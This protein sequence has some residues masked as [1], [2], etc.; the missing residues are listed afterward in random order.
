MPLII[1]ATD[2]SAVAENAANYACRLAMAQN[3]QLTIIHSF[4]F[5]V[6][7][8]DIPLPAN[9]INDTED[10]LD[11]QMKKL[12]TRLKTAYPTLNIQGIVIDGDLIKS[13]EE[14]VK[15]N[16][17]PWLVV[18]GN[19][20]A[21]EYNTWESIVLA[22]FK[23][24]KYPVLAVPPGANYKQVKKICLAFDNK[25]EGND[26]A[27]TQLRDI[28]LALNAEL[29]ILNAQEDVLNRDNLPIT[30]ELAQQI[31]A[32]A[33]PHFHVIY[34]ANINN[35]IEDFINK[36]DIDWLVMIPRKHS[37][38]EGLFHKSHSKAMAHHTHIPIVALHETHT[39]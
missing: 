4:V 11:A 6:M 25:H 36:N 9:L 37:F 2:F 39:S 31:L 14:Y 8:S 26:V 30:D 29:Q 22:A 15:N 35:A 38:F 3:A 10:D 13:L 5:P 23:Q 1:T 16:S 7:F 17:E 18:L 12:V 34:E 27:F 33:N 32:P 19:S 24:L 20:N 21:G 28:A